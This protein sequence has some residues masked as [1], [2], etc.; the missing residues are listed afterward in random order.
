MGGV[1]LFDQFVANYR[2]RIRSKKW[3]WPFFAWSLNSAAV[4]SWRL[5]R[6]L[7][8]NKIPLLQFIREIVLESLGKYGK[9]RPQTS[10]NTSGIAGNSIKLDT[11]DHV[12]VKG[13]SKY[14][15]C[16]NCGRRTIYKCEKCNVSLHADCMKDY[17]KWHLFLYDNIYISFKYCK[18]FKYNVKVEKVAITT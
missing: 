18:K 15:R 7:H 6:N 16:K 9:N 11:K 1:D 12:L 14:C 2:V 8:G 17:H 3:W 4:N 13:V 5:Y 10:L